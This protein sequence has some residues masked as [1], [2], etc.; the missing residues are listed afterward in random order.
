MH[1]RI[2]FVHPALF[3][4]ALKALGPCLTLR[5]FQARSGI[6]GET[7]ARDVLGYLVRKGIGQRSKS[8]YSFSKSDKITLAILALQNGGDLETISRALSWQD[9]EAF[10]SSLLNLAGYMSE[11]NLYLSNPYRMQ[12]DVIGVNHKSRLV[13]AVDCK[14]WR[15]NHLSSMLNHARKQAMRSIEL[16]KCRL[17]FFQ[18]VPIV[19]TLYP[20]NIQL[21]EG[22][23]I[24]PVS[25]FNSFI[26]ELPVSLY[27]INVLSINTNA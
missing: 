7:T 24:V 9:F 19:L 21:V 27:K 20:M 2:H 8:K 11:C 18:A 10:A 22:T 14:H 13:V 23:P 12:I 6:R 4:V 16:L 26:Q 15:K 17:N 25:K 3:S 1:Y 5:E